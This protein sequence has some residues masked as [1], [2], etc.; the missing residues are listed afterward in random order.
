MD[1][2]P[3]EQRCRQRQGDPVDRHRQPA[4]LRHHPQQLGPGEGDVAR[5]LEHVD[6]IDHPDV[7]LHVLVVERLALQPV[8]QLLD[9]QRP[10]VGRRADR[11][12]QRQVERLPEPPGR[13]VGTHT[14]T[15]DAATEHRGVPALVGHLGER[16]L[17]VPGSRVALGDHL[18]QQVHQCHLGEDAVAGDA[19]DLVLGQLEPLFGRHLLPHRG[20]VER[21]PVLG[22][23]VLVVRQRGRP[24][25]VDLGVVGARRRGAQEPV[26]DL[27]AGRLR[28]RQRC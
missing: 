26:G 22:Q 17:R 27:L 11:Q 19:D 12:Q 21:D 13:Q 10:T 25:D 24:V 14:G 28:L 18:E 2:Q 6:P 5:L 23:V 1:H 8:E 3:D 20:A 7:R 15:L 4:D 9:Q 16:V